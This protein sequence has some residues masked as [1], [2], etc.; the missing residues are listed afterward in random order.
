MIS[1][2]KYTDCPACG[3]KHHFGLPEGKWPTGCVCEYVCPET[4]RRSS[5]RIDQPGEEARYYPQGAVQLK[6]LAATA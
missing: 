5:L 2:L 1:I 4:G 6:P 3:R